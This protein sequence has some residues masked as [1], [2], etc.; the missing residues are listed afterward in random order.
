MWLIPNLQTLA[1]CNPR[2]VCLQIIAVVVELNRRYWWMFTVFLML[3]IGWG[4][5]KPPEPG[6]VSI[7]GLDKLMHFVAYLCLAL[8]TAL[9][10]RQQQWCCFLGLVLFGGAVE[11][12]QPWFGRSC[13]G[14]DFVT[15]CLGVLTGGWF[16][17]R[18]YQKLL[19]E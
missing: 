8:P 2:S 3:I 6:D 15:N 7:A 10:V 13:D 12:L 11:L 5:L 17:R 1:V 14:L 4:S 19:P 16:V 9:A 18:I